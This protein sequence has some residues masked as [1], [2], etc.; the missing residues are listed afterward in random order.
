MP[1]PPSEVDPL[2]VKIPLSYQLVDLFDQFDKRGFPIDSP[3]SP[4]LVLWKHNCNSKYASCLSLGCPAAKLS[5]RK[6]EQ[7]GIVFK[8][9]IHECKQGRFCDNFCP[10]S[11]WRF[12][13]KNTKYEEFYNYMDKGISKLA[14]EIASRYNG[15]FKTN[16]L[17]PLSA[18]NHPKKASMGVGEKKL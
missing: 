14:K 11:C 10:K 2:T 7:W 1:P 4:Y 8:V 13:C 3:A 15:N 18:C 6:W 9:P 16:H 12:T 17:F 5:K